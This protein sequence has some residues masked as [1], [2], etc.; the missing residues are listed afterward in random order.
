MMRGK[1]ITVKPHVNKAKYNSVSRPRIRQTKRDRR[2]IAL[3]SVAAVG[4]CAAVGTVL[5]DPE[6]GW[7]KSLRKP[8]WQ[9]PAAAFPIVWTT[10]YADIAYV[11]YK[12]LA[13]A[14][15]RKDT[16]EFKSYAR[17]LGTNLVLNATWCSLFFRGER[18]VVSTIEAGALAVS[19]IDLVRRAGKS[20]PGLGVLLSPYALWTSGATALSGA[21]AALN[22]GK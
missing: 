9:P 8:D 6:N 16:T 19:S 3:G 12:V 13:D 14:Q 15:A 22:P 21:I 10:L 11:S 18:P 5:T 2:K 17:A 1:E 7:Y 4:A 20:H